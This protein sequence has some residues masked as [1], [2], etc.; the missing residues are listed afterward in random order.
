MSVGGLSIKA[1]SAMLLAAAALVAMSPSMA[2][3]APAMRVVRDPVTGQL[4]APTASEFKAMQAREARDRA[5]S[6]VVTPAPVPLRA[7]NGAVGY[8][9]GDRFLSY[10]VAKR[11]A[12]GT[13]SLDCVTG[14]EAANQL[15]NAP[16]SS[17]AAIHE[18]HDH[19]HE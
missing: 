3:G 19:A 4:R 13:V 17:T 8:R 9:V 14:A 12:D 15:L 11:S 2:A 5:A 18:E 16:Q 10:S 7:A 1:G 6:R